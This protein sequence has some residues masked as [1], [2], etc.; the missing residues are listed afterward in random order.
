MA[1]SISTGRVDAAGLLERDAELEQLHAA[2]A[3]AERGDGA[4]VLVE[5][6]AGIGKTSLLGVGAAEAQQRGFSVV[7]ARGGELEREFG[8]GVVRQMFE[9]VLVAGPAEARAQL[10]SGPAAIAESILGLGDATMPASGQD[11][12]FAAQHGLYWL[13]ANL[14]GRGPLLLC[15]DDAQ[16]AD[17]ASLRWLVFLARRLEGV[18]AVVLVGWR[19]GEPE[20]PIE[21]LEALRSEA[22]KVIGPRPLSQNAAAALVRAALGTAADDAFCNACQEAAGGNPF[23]LTELI[24]ALAR[25]DVEAS[26]AGAQRAREMG[27]SAVARSVLLRLS[28][29]PEDATA[30]AR[31][32]AVLDTDAD[33]HLAAAVAGLDAARAVAAAEALAG[34]QILAAGMPLRFAHPILRAAVY[35]E[36]APSRRALEH[37]RAAEVLASRD[38]D[39]AAVH[40]RSTVPAGDPWVAEQLLGAGQRAAGRGAIDAAAALLDRCLAEPPPPGRVATAQLARGRAAYSSGDMR[41]AERCLSQAVQL[42]DDA[43]LRASAATE[44]GVGRFL[45]GAMGRALDALALATEEVPPD[46]QGRRAEIRLTRVGFELSDMKV[47]AAGVGRTLDELVERSDP[48]WASHPMFAAFG[49]YRPFLLDGVNF[50]DVAPTL[51]A[52]RRLHELVASGGSDRDVLQIGMAISGLHIS[53]EPEAAVLASS[54]LVDLAREQGM[55]SPLV[56]GLAMRARSYVQ[57]GRLLEADV[58]AR[59]SVQLAALSGAGFLRLFAV[60]GHVLALVALGRLDEAET[61]LQ[62]HGLTTSRPVDTISDALV[63]Q[64]R[65][66]LR[67]G[68]HREVEALADLDAVEQAFAA[69]GLPLAPPYMPLLERPTMLLAAGRQAE[70]REAA[71]AGLAR[72][73][74]LAPTYHGLLLRPAGLV[75]PGDEGLAL[76]RAACD[77]LEG[78]SLRLDHARALIDLGSALRRTNRR[79]DAREPLQRGME[80]AHTCA[81]EPLLEKAHTELL[82]TGARPR[83]LMRSGVDALTPSERRVAELAAQ[84]LSNPQIAQQLFVTRKTVETHMGSILRRLDLKSRDELAPLLASKPPAPSAPP[85]RSMPAVAPIGEGATTIVATVLFTDIVDSTARAAKLGAAAWRVLLDRHDLV[86]RE[87]LRAHGGREIKT[88]GDGFL[89]VFNRSANA[90]VCAVATRDAMRG[91]GLPIRAGLHAGEVEITTRDIR[92]LAVNAAARIVALAEP[93]EVLLSATVRD[94]TIGSAMNLTPRGRY[95]LKGVPGE[96]DILRA[97]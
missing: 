33:V 70:A 13:T 37:R 90:V 47:A 44:L 20:V 75:T 18:R 58:D 62:D 52:A 25:G 60:S 76:L 53:G 5:G 56:T 87:Q 96:W 27:P 73:A 43:E 97:N 28:R 80:L 89:A 85:A 38:A 55:L 39:R 19:S 61:V 72:M 86:V 10:L 74:K 1:V 66:L 32:V 11:A 6:E 22:G 3:A 34:A 77:A 84:G 54:R 65:A 7:R 59:E 23:L 9:P 17:V 40:L 4:L 36:L 41:V 83:R 8:F 14:A 71:S 48:E 57:L 94:L 30:L 95:I 16:W 81:A 24:S 88:L 67:S 26:A 2:L 12:T 92:G 78:S 64:V 50:D 29:L 79:A 63:L 51:P 35:D 68:Q 45:I 91:L 93:G 46:A 15:V 42:A 69:R 31:A 82:A 21:L 49:L